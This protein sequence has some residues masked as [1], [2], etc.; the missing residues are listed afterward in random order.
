MFDK[1]ALSATPTYWQNLQALTVAGV[2]FSVPGNAIATADLLAHIDTVFGTNCARRGKIYAEK[3]N[4]R[5]RHFSRDMIKQKEGPRK[6]DSNPEL[7]ARAL[8]SALDNAGLKPNDLGYIIAHTA[9]PARPIPN[10][11]AFTSDIL[12][13]SG[14]YMELRQ[15]CTGFANALVIAYGLLSQSGAKPIA[16]VG[17]ETGS[18][19]FDPK[20]LAEDSGQLVNLVQMGDA[21]AAIILKPGDEDGLGKLSH[22]FFGHIGL[23]RDPGFTLME[24]G[25]DAPF[26]DLE[27]IEFAHEFSSVRANGPELFIAGI[28]AALQIGCDLTKMDHIIPHQANG[29]MGALMAE[30]LGID[31]SH[32]YVNAHRRGNTGSAA[33]WLAFAELMPLLTPGETV[34]T[35]GAEATKYL[36]GGFQYT[37][38]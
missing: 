1:T 27:V 28:Q 36:Y 15:A 12:E 6:G 32:V 24:G 16:I 22:A 8:T 9:T 3:L 29:N 30:H 10:N 13:Y 4:I 14:P 2:G 17:S 11:M 21:A 35:L 23:G 38:G 20:R 7:T 33:I 25:S 34:I 26:T 19:Y 18:S 37:H 5:K 31:G